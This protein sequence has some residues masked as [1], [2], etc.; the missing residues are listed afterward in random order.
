MSAALTN[1]SQAMAVSSKF[2][3][4]TI[5]S[6]RELA[7]KGAGFAT[8]DEVAAAIRGGGVATELEDAVNFELLADEDVRTLAE[9]YHY[10]FTR[11]SHSLF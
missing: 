2:I 7:L 6:P 1:A 3:R 9:L 5:M 10:Y 4:P 8:S 11:G